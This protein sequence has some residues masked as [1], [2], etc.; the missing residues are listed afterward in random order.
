M[1]TV[2]GVELTMN[3]TITN[4]RRCKVQHSEAQQGPWSDAWNFVVESKSEHTWHAR[5]EYGVLTKRFKQMLMDFSGNLEIAWSLMDSNNT[6][7]LSKAEFEDVCLR[8]NKLCGTSGTA[9]IEPNKLFRDL[10]VEN[11]GT[12]SVEQIFSDE[13]R[14]PVAPFW[15][16]L[17]VDNWGSPHSVVLANPL[18]LFST[19]N[20]D[21]TSHT[22]GKQ[23]Y[24]ETTKFMEEMVLALQ[25]TVM[26]MTPEEQF[27]PHVERVQHRL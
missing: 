9:L 13:V 18:R 23:A 25:P 20:T 6:G 3:G 12:I 21:L 5:H 8:V 10:D 1:G 14:M 26:H 27:A 7:I 22:S 19:V 4:P 2:T 24:H 16:L 17:I 15:R 11:Q